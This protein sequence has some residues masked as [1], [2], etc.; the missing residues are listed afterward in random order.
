MKK[1]ILAAILLA[2]PC[3]I[4]AGAPGIAFENTYRPIG[5]RGISMGG[6]YTAGVADAA[7]LNWNPAL[8]DSLVKN[9]ASISF[10]TLFEGASFSYLSYV[11]PVGKIGGIGISAAYLDMG[12]YEVTDTDGNGQGNNRMNEIHVTAGYGKNLFMGVAGGIALKVVSQN[13]G[14]E[15]FTGFTA[16][17]G[18]FRPIGD[19]VEAGLCVK[20][21]LPLTVKYNNGQDSF[22]PAIRLGAAVKLL[23]DKLRFTVDAEKIFAESDFS[24]FSGV[25]YNVA[26]L[27]YVRGGYNTYGE[28]GGGI[29]VTY[30]DFVF[31]YGAGYNDLG[32]S[33]RAT[34]AYRFGGYALTLKAEP[35]VFSPLGGNRKSYI[36]ISAQHKYEIYKWRVEVKDAAGAVVKEWDGPANPPDTVIWDGLKKDGMPMADGDYTARLTITDEND[37]VVK[38]GT[39]NIKISGQDKYYMPMYGD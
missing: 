21:A 10:E 25:E 20:N 15:S 39:I 22:A 33:H 23:D 27:V 37:A 4:L 5:T 1:T 11:N 14:S 12:E 19:Y 32:L 34:L 6:A 28:I 29:G 18:L 35:D 38:S 8:L 3:I 7:I 30:S 16:D 2:L 17:V 9:E 13:L 31:D 36:R 26:D 24:V